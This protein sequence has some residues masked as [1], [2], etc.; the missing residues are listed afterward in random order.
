MNAGE[1]GQKF[2]DHLLEQYKL[3]VEMTDRVS[4]RRSQTNRFYVSLLSGL[5][6]LL[7]LVA[8]NGGLGQIPIVLFVAVAALGMLLC[9]LWHVNIRVYRQLNW[10][11]FQVINEMEQHLPFQSYDREWKILQEGKRGSRFRGISKVE[12]FVPF[13]VALPFVLLLVYSFVK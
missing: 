13:I 8:S 2:G 7:S 9:L 4:T 5:L 12:Q 1:Y 11:K 6:A 10:G 3:Y